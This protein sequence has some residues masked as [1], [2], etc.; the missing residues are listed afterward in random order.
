MQKAIARRP[1]LAVVP[2][3]IGL[4]RDGVLDAADPNGNRSVAETSP[5]SPRITLKALVSH[6]VGEPFCLAHTPPHRAAN[7]SGSGPATNSLQ[8]LQR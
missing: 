6:S 3:G 4:G 7:H 5:R 8:L 1:V 2:T